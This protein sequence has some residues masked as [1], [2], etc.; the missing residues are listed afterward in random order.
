MLVGVY[1]GTATMENIMEGPQKI[2]NRI[3]YD[4]VIPFDSLFER[5]KKK[6]L[7]QKA[8]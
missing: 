3:L 6:T 2:K 1:I 5:E 7:I 4:P 8:K